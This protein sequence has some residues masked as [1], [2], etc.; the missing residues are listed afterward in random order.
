MKKKIVISGYYGFKNLGDEA[1]LHALLQEIRNWEE[2]LELLVLSGDPGFTSRT[3]GVA[4]AHR[5]P[6][7]RVKEALENCDIFLTGGGSLLQDKTGFKSIPYYLGLTDL[8]RRKGARNA[9]ICCGIGPISRPYL[10]WFA[11]WQLGKMDF[12][13]VRDSFSRELLQEIGVQQEPHLIPDPVFL[14]PPTDT[15]GG[16]DKCFGG[17]LPSPRSRI[18]IAPR[19]LPGAAGL[20]P[21]PW[22]DLCTRLQQELEGELVLWPLHSGEDRELCGAI[23][24]HLQGIT[25]MENSY[26]I[27]HNLEMLQAADLIIG[28]RLH[29]LIMG[30]VAGASLL[31]ISYDPKVKSLLENLGLSSDLE[32]DNFSPEEVAV[33]A[34]KI[35]RGDCEEQEQLP[36]RVASLGKKSRQG[37]Q[38]LRDFVRREPHG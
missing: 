32:L 17:E 12:L 7:S 18:I 36:S 26:S 15:G 38:L 30:A 13:S 14:L 11:R 10:K 2:D 23:S 24:S 25:V 21:D 29:A 19:S 1:I 9:L 35:L 20:N 8:A 33:R 16:G 4:G 3:H 28:V 31:G 27:P 6:L 5:W 37:M 22:I 34:G